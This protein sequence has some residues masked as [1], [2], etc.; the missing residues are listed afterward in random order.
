MMQEYEQGKRNLEEHLDRMPDLVSETC[1]VLS[2]YSFGECYTW[3]QTLRRCNITAGISRTPWGRI[4][5]V[6]FTY[7]TSPEVNRER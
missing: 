1:H 6:A 2:S 3:P 5:L 7:H 4:V